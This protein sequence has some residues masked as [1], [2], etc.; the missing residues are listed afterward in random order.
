MAIKFGLEE[1]EVR[2]VDDRNE[3]RIKNQTNYNWN[4]YLMKQKT[5]EAKNKWSK[6]QMKQIT[7]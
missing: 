4:Q 5:N 1:L 7:N 3:Q 6:K 2:P